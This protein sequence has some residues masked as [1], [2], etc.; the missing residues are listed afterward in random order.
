MTRR[1]L[2]KLK[3]ELLQLRR[4]PQKA[5]A[6][7]RFAK[8]LGRKRVKRGKEPMWESSEFDELYA[9]SIPHHAGR[10][11]AIGT[12]NSILDQL[13]NDLLAWEAKLEKDEEGENNSDDGEDDGSG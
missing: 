4:S 13:E 5:A 8:R 2:D 1:K 11:L 6:L 7:E 3:R 12:K 10:D 9:L